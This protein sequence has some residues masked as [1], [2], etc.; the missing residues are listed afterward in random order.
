[1]LIQCDS[2]RTQEELPTELEL[3]IE[4]QKA[5]AAEV[6]AL[7]HLRF[8]PNSTA[9]RKCVMDAAAAYDAAFTAWLALP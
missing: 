3:R 2:L 9:L 7:E 6:R 8:D 1:M 5:E 4:C